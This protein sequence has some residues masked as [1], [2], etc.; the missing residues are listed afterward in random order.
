M[1]PLK[2][3]SRKRRAIHDRLLA[4]IPAETPTSNTLRSAL[5]THEYNSLEPES[6]HHLNL[7]VLLIEQENRAKKKIPAAVMFG[8]GRVEKVV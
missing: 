8:L 2:R 7:L 5:N 1:L 4:I 3:V 6:S